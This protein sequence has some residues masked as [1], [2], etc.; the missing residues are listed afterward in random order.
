MIMKEVKAPLGKTNSRELTKVE[1]NGGGKFLFASALFIGSVLA[2]KKIL[3]KINN[4]KNKF[5][6]YKV[7]KT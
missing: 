5:R 3:K 4:R 2:I 7:A 6:V 1:N